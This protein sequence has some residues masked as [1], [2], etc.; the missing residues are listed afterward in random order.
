MSTQHTRP[1]RFKALTLAA[2]PD[3]RDRV[4]AQ[5]AGGG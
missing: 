3:G 2:S 4:L 5:R 1:S